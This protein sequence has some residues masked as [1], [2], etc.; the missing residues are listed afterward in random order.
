MHGSLLT[1]MAAQAITH[2]RAGEAA[3]FYLLAP[4]AVGSSL[5]M[6]F[7]KNTV[8][9]ALSLVAVFFCLAVF[10]ALQDAPFLAAVQVIV[11][12]GAIMVLF[13]FVIMLVGVDHA[14]SLVET[15]RGQRMASVAFAFGFIALLTAT[16][17]NAVVHT[18]ATG[19]A[20]ANA[21]G[22]VQGLAGLIFTTY[23]VPF[24]LTSALLIVAALSAMVLA[25]RERT[26]SRPTQPELMRA[27][28]RDAG[29]EPVET[30]YHERISAKDGP[31]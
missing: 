28:F 2:T 21:G 18:S 31:E 15:I 6:V 7:T 10:Y 1:A 19:L 14:D 9:A 24:E 12:A 25:H 8:H 17:G 29:A 23:V 11:Y 26:V 22:N 16:I 4:I 5:A 13:L 20:A 30:A 3:T 27:R